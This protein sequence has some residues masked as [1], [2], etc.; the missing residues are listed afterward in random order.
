MSKPR[1]MMVEKIIDEVL[2]DAGITAFAV[3]RPPELPATA[4]VVFFAN[5][6]SDETRVTENARIEVEGWGR[7]TTE[8][9]DILDAAETSILEAVGSRGIRRAAGVTKPVSL[10]TNERGW[11]RYTLAM[12]IS[13]RPGK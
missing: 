9:W 12:E 5:G 3:R 6:G 1:R 13:H 8:A 11:E 7:T 10:G 2:Y 4:F